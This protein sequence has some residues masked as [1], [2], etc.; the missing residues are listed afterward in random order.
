MKHLEE[1]YVQGNRS[2]KDILFYYTTTGKNVLNYDDDINGLICIYQRILLDTHI[3]IFV[4]GWMMWNW[5]VSALALGTTL[6]LYDGSPLHPHPEV[7]WDLVDACGITVFG[8]SAKWIAVQ[9]DRGLK[10]R[11]SHKLSTLKV[12]FFLVTN[13][14]IFNYG[15]YN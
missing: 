3:S 12:L 6:V 7:M 5:M 10:P 4:L 9:E 8:T 2:D 1:H 13:G 14:R 11:V 15:H